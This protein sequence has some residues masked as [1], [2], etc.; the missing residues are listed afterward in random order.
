MDCLIEIA[1]LGAVG[2]T[3]Q[4][5]PISQ[6][7]DF[8]LLALDAGAHLVK[9]AGQVPDLVPV[10]HGRQRLRIV[11]AAELLQPLRPRSAKAQLHAAPGRALPMAKSARP[12]AVI[13]SRASCTFRQ[14]A[15]T[16]SSERS[17]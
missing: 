17:T 4:S 14:G 3:G 2:Q 11:S 7:H 8:M 16:S 10:A 13:S 6:L 5:I 15:T 9:R 1:K 12:T